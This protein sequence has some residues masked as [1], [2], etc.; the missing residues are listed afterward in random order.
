MPWR[1]TVRLRILWRHSFR[2][3]SSARRV[4]G[5][6]WHWPRYFSLQRSGCAAIKD[7]SDS[8]EDW[9]PFRTQGETS[10]STALTTVRITETSPQVYARI[11]GVLYL[12]I[13]VIGF[14][15]EFFVRDKLVVSGDVTGGWATFNGRKTPRFSL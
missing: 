2:P 6:G 10:M 5:P 11:G 12:I 1:R 8:L 3:I 14:C 4:C 13:I 15:S 7:R 9:T